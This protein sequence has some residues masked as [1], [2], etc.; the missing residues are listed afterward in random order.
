MPTEDKHIPGFL[1]TK[2]DPE[3][4]LLQNNDQM[5]LVPCELDLSSISLGNAK[6]ITYE[7][8]FPPT[9]KKIG[10]NFMDDN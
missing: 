4:F 9:G 10:F 2:Q 5:N 6:I 7:L 8:W 1:L 3:I